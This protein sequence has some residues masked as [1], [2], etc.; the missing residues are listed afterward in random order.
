MSRKGKMP[1][2]IPKGVEVKVA[3]SQVTVKGPK[4]TLTH[5]VCPQVTV[6]VDGQQILVGV[7]KDD[8]TL[9]KYHGLFRT[10]IA[11]MVQGVQEPF[12][13]TL[14]MIGVGYRAAVMGHEL[15]LQLGFSHPTRIAIPNGVK[16]DIDKGTILEIS[17]CDKALVGQFCANIR[18]IKPPEPYQGKG[19]RYADE[20]V[21]RKAGKAAAKTTATK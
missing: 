10:L 11:N 12:K 6:K 18:A 21:R 4:G 7:T 14:H 9:S 3:G 5:D 1:I 20:Y 16:V 19:I 2:V 8:K 15:D 13:V 17:G